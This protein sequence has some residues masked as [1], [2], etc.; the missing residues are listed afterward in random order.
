MIELLKTNAGRIIAAGVVTNK[1]GNQFTLTGSEWDREKKKNMERN[2]VLT[3]SPTENTLTNFSAINNG[4]FVAVIYCPN[5]ED[6]NS[7]NVEHLLLEGEA[8]P[9]KWELQMGPNKGKTETR[10]LV[11]GSVASVKGLN[12]TGNAYKLSFRDIRLEGTEDYVGNPFEGSYGTSYW[13]NVSVFNPRNMKENQTPFW[14]IEKASKALVSGTSGV[15]VLKKSPW[16][17][18]DGN[19]IMLY[20]MIKW[21]VP[22]GTASNNTVVPTRNAQPTF[23]PIPDNTVDSTQNAQ[24]AFTPIPD[25]VPQQI[26]PET[27][28]EPINLPF[29]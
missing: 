11:N 1:Q 6:V 28:E 26:Q 22:N 8:C 25:N 14:G 16:K 7:G 4:D 29:L 18:P 12:K 9:F 17:A 13:M 21:I 15:F 19:T 20:N 27:Q 5:A 2:I 3:A 23:T 24:P 10:W